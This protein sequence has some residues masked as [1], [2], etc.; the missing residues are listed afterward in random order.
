MT[1][2]QPLVADGYGN[3]EMALSQGRSGL[4]GGR[5]TSHSSSRSCSTPRTT[6][7]QARD[8]E[9]MPPE[10]V[11]G[12][13]QRAV[14][15]PPLARRWVAHGSASALTGPIAKPGGYYGKASDASA[16]GFQ[17]DG[18]WGFGARATQTWLIPDWLAV[19]NQ[20]K[21]DLAAAIDLSQFGMPSLQLEPAFCQQDES[22]CPDTAPQPKT[23]L[24]RN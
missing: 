3:A 1:L 5:P 7:A 22:R 12:A 24:P 16:C 18:E 2:N 13:A 6:R 21:K 9:Q 4:S 19:M 14:L 15:P 17:F 20:A 11:L 23:H 10:A 8:A